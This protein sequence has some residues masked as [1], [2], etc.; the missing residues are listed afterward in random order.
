MNP[1]VSSV[2]SL[3]HPFA[4][5]EMQVLRRFREHRFSEQW[6]ALERFVAQV[7]S[8]GILNIGLLLR[9][10]TLCLKLDEAAFST[11]HIVFDTGVAFA[12]STLPLVSCSSSYMAHGEQHPLWLRLPPRSGEARRALSAYLFMLGSC[13]RR[14]RWCTTS[15]LDFTSTMPRFWFAIC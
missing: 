10:Y 2:R 5:L 9:E 6:L 14:Q 15:L 11:H 13:L 4:V 3:P 7:I 8:N 12:E 1:G